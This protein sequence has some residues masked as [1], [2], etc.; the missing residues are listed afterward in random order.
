MG[1][2]K[3]VQTPGVD[4]LSFRPVFVTN[5]VNVNGAQGGWGYGYQKDSFGNQGPG[6]PST[7]SVV[8]SP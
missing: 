2:K 4:S 8:S 5:D 6:R 7:P 1:K 3:K